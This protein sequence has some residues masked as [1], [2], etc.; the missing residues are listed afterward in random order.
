MRKSIKFSLIGIIILYVLYFIFPYFIS[1]KISN[2]PSS[3]VIYDSN[4]EEIGEIV[5]EGKYRHRIIDYK[6]EKYDFLK[7]VVISLED[8]RFYYHSGID[9]ISFFRASLQNLKAGKILEGASTIDSQVIRNSLWLNETRNYK[10][11][12]E[13]FIYALA[14]NKK[15]SKDEILNLY[16]NNVYFGYLNYGFE[17]A[18]IYY[19]GKDLENLTKAEILAL[20][21]IPKNSNNYDPLKKKEAF[22]KRFNS[23]LNTLKTRKIISEEEYKDIKQEKLIWNTEHKNK[24]PYITDFIA[25]TPPASLPP[26][27]GGLEEE[28]KI[29]TTIDYYMTKEIE[30]ISYNAILKL[31]WKNVTDYSVI[32][33]DKKTNELKTMIGGIDYNSKNGQVNSRTSLR[34]AGSTI[35]AFT[36]YLAFKNLGLSPSSKIL[37]LPVSFQTKE[38][39]QYSPKNYD[40]TYH[41]E[42][43]LAKALSQSI[44]IPAVKLTEQIGVENLLNFLKKVGITSLNQTPEHYGLA[45]TLGVGEVSLYELTRAYSIFAHDGNLCDISFISE[46]IGKCSNIA[47]KKYTDM[48]SEIL[49]NRYFKLGGFPINSSLDFPYRNVFVKTG[50]SRNFRDNWAIG[51]T[52][53]YIIGVWVGN[54]DASNMKG[55]SGASGAG[56]VFRNIVY[57]LEPDNIEQ[58]AKENIDEKIDNYLEI[59]SPLQN[60]VYYFDKNKNTDSQS[61]KIEFSTN[62]NY[63]KVFYIVDDEILKNEFWNLKKGFH[64]ISVKLMK[65]GEI[66]ETKSTNISVE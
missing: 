22:E 34:Q 55:V 48:V 25:K 64:K 29:Q 4:N 46:N 40:L 35:K 15:Y 39:Y 23:L 52:D 1:I 65:N 37:D 8:R 45:L 3:Q 21:T 30:K 47:E 44:N 6:D 50:T 51:Y 66:I 2:F 19:F 24:L 33:L 17:S 14:L 16:L 31:F 61:I 28:G 56:E 9:F 53:N 27:G 13:E 62:Y 10:K 12:I 26:Q 32:V 11:K 58:K 49:T 20:A 43:S 38:G 42:V 54:K 7:K 59:T 18:S 63:D 57:Y 60:S 36:Y 5:A 41:G